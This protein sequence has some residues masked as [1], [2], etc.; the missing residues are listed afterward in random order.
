[1]NNSWALRQNKVAS[2]PA[3]ESRIS[4]WTLRFPWWNFSSTLVHHVR[5]VIPETLSMPHL[6]AHLGVVSIP[7]QAEKLIQLDIDASG[8][9]RKVKRVWISFSSKI[10]NLRQNQFRHEITNYSNSV[11]KHA[12][13]WPLSQ[14][15]KHEFQNF[16]LLK[17]KWRRAQKVLYAHARQPSRYRNTTRRICDRKRRWK[18]RS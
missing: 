17:P 5:D 16:V 6:G 1:M 3:P 8:W 11:P 10:G 9:T 7:T 4:L 12:L 15:L 18:A 13:A 2:R 14:Y